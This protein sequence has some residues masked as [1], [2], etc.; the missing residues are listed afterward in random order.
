MKSAA[1]ELAT[2]TPLPMA[3][4]PQPDPQPH[5]M[6]SAHHLV[7]R[8]LEGAIGRLGRAEHELS[9]G[10]GDSLA[11]A[12][13]IIEALQDSLDFELGG[14]LAENLF[15]LYDYMLRRL[16]RAACHADGAALREVVNLLETIQQGWD[17]IG[18]ELGRD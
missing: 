8:L 17:A 13:A 14:Q 18:P 3:A 11:A 2:V 10:G 9:Q 4:A 7:S 15:D 1:S 12:V 5:A 16:G 6:A